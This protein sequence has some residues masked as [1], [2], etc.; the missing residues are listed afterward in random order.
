[1]RPQ[2]KVLCEGMIRREGKAILEARSSS[3]LVTSE[4]ELIVVDTSTREYRARILEALDKYGLRPHDITILVST[5]S[6]LDHRGNDDLFPSARR[7][8]MIGE[9]EPGESIPLASGV[10]MVRTPGH[11]PDSGSVFV[12]GEKR[13]A[14]A[15]DAI[16]TRDNI[17]KWLPPGIHYDKRL[18]LRSMSMIVRFADVVIPGHGPPFELDEIIKIRRKGNGEDDEREG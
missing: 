8:S 1:M 13:F 15:G 5:H 18:A 7:L 2:V 4:R 10:V 6:H 17:M 11:T 3:V 9:G 12:E 16:P 14:I